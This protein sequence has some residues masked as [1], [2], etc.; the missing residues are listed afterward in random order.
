MERD[1]LVHKVLEKADKAKNLIYWEEN[2]RKRKKTE[3]AGKAE[4]QTNILDMSL[5]AR[6]VRINGLNS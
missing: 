2:N 6:V 3:K 4:T 5:I 1:Y